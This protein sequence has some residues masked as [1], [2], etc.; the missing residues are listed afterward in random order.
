MQAIRSV[1][2]A[3]FSGTGG[4][5]RVAEEIEKAFL[6]KSIPAR[7]SEL[8]R[9]APV[10]HD[11]DL[12]VLLFA[13]YALRAPRP[14][15]E[16]IEQ[17]PPGNG[18]PAAVISV[19]AGGEISPNAN[20][21]AAVIRQL[22]L[23]GY[24]VLYEGMFVM[25]CNFLIRYDDALCAMLLKAAPRKANR[26]ASDILAGTRCRKKPLLFDRLL[27]T[28]GLLEKR[29]SGFF[30]KHLYATEGCIGCGWCEKHCPRGNISLHSGKPLF[31]AE[32][33]IC[34]RCVYGCPQNA[35]IPGF[36]KSFVLQDGFNIQAI[37]RRT[38]HLT[39]FP[40]LNQIAKGPI[41]AGVRRY[42]KEELD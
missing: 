8:I 33:V 30:G 26:I 39:Q 37:E 21:R 28:I 23:K 38:S 12:L 3:Y 9:N 16:W 25:P 1:H 14:V 4:T 2:L 18:R 36:A 7:K 11:E 10:V 35:I 42:L 15:D 5:A 24:D 34:L 32:C 17:A 41:M 40:P 22:E 27:S 29:N 6:E 19:S 20:C 31:G 13:V